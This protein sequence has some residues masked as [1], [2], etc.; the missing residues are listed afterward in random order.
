MTEEARLLAVHPLLAGLGPRHL[1]SMAACASATS[2]PAGRRVFDEGAP[3]DA[4]WL[5]HEGRVN[6]V[7]HV[8]GR[9]DVVVETIGCGQ[10]LGWSWL[11]PPYRWQFGA[12]A[13]ELMAAVRLD[14]A[15]VRLRCD[16]DP[17]LGYE[18]TMR[19][20]PVLVERMQGT[21]VRLLDLYDGAS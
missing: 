5:I 19:F 12:V 2:V 9:G 1:A 20:I 16:A 17:A 18:L 10:V 14:G 13:V 21:R 4:F 7:T 11:L 15:L 8:P 3:A 6:L